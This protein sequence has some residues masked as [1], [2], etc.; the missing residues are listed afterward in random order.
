MC[1]LPLNAWEPRILFCAIYCHSLVRRHRRICGNLEGPPSISWMSD[2]YSS[3][4]N[5][6]WEPCSLAKIGSLICIQVSK[7]Q[8]HNGLKFRNQYHF[9]ILK[10]SAFEF[11]N[12]RKTIIKYCLE[13]WFGTDVWM[14][15]ID[16][17]FWILPI[18]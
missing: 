13:E 12:L 15:V 17:E 9:L 10:W 16:L 5:H 14:K 6:W 3:K 8:K 1:G 7:Y 18:W 2:N 4:K 11:D